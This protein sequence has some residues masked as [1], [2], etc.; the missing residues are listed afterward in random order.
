[1]SD[2][3]SESNKEMKVLHDK[4]AKEKAAAASLRVELREALG[5]RLGKK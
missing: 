1:M 3:I 4:L 5:V 2:L